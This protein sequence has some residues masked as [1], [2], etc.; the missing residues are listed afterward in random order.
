MDID[1]KSKKK[2]LELKKP[3]VWDLFESKRWAIGVLV[4]ASLIFLDTAHIIGTLWVHFDEWASYHVKAEGVEEESRKFEIIGTMVERPEKSGERYHILLRDV[5]T[6]KEETMEVA[7]KC[8]MKYTKGQTVWFKVPIRDW[9]PEYVP[10]RPDWLPNL[11]GLRVG[12]YGFIIGIM[13]IAFAIGE[14]GMYR[15]W[16]Y[17]SRDVLD[18]NRY[19]DFCKKTTYKDRENMYEKS[20]KISQRIIISTLLT[21]FLLAWG[22]SILL[23]IL[24]HGTV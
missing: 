21:T 23:L 12:I 20:K 3:S 17:Y 1:K 8:Y 4:V 18:K 16:W 5:Q 13:T 7:R 19:R 11:W 24:A 10:P 14:E 2:D 9:V 6:K 15:S 22:G